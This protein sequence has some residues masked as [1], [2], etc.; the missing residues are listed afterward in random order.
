MGRLGEEA[1]VG[2][3]VHL[4]VEVGLVQTGDAT[5][6]WACL[7][8]GNIHVKAAPTVESI[9]LCKGFCLEFRRAVREVPSI[10]TDVP[11]HLCYWGFDCR[12][13]DVSDV[14]V[15]LR[16]FLS[17]NR[18]MWPVPPPHA[19]HTTVELA[20]PEAPSSVCQGSGTLGV[21]RGLGCG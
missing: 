1:L 17:W 18:S 2:W 3:S 6:G 4:G 21:Y 11:D 12:A 8:P 5:Q 10:C 16:S 15:L 7:E 9:C 14:M 20:P 13:V 19:D